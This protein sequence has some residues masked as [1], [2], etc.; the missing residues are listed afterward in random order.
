MRKPKIYYQQTYQMDVYFLIGWPVK[1]YNKYMKRF[2][3]ECDPSVDQ[4][5]RTNRNEYKGRKVL[6][7]WVENKKHHDVIAHECLHAANFLLNFVGVV[8]SFENDEAQ[9]YLLGEL[10]RK[11]YE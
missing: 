8:P 1:A 7:I 6:I 9:A 4:A 3:F 10:V 11:A 2:D 5:G